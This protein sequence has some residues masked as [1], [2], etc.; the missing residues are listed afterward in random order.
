MISC[1]TGDKY[2]TKKASYHHPPVQNKVKPH[3]SKKACPHI[4]VCLKLNSPPNVTLSRT[5]G[6]V[7]S[8][9]A[10]AVAMALPLPPRR[11]CA[12]A[13]SDAWAP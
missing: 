2:N 10:A 12:A 4:F 13:S 5:G 7:V 11:G 6:V 9:A 3:Y 8:A 1:S